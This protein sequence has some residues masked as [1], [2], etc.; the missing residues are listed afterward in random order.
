M[1]DEGIPC[2]LTKA[3]YASSVSKKLILC[4]W[5]KSLA[6]LRAK[7]RGPRQP[8]K[9]L[10]PQL[11]DASGIPV[12]EPSMSRRKSRNPGWFNRDAK[13]QKLPLMFAADILIFVVVF[14][15]QANRRILLD[16]SKL[17][18]LGRKQDLSRRTGLRM[19][20]GDYVKRLHLAVVVL[21]R[22]TLFLAF[23]CLTDILVL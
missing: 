9:E 12:A 23:H 17:G 11:P 5:K 19:R 21:V 4:S 1:A 10:A 16:A 15:I 13:S 20:T 3:K 18:K 7:E 6:V 22:R 2:V 8:A 14:G